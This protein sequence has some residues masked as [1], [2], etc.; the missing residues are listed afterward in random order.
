MFLYFGTPKTSDAMFLDLRKSSTPKYLTADQ[1]FCSLHIRE[2]FFK[3]HYSKRN[4]REN[5]SLATGGPA[6]SFCLATVD[7]MVSI[8]ASDLVLVLISS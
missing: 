1:T 2:L 4:T 3:H 6:D 8:V 7:E 5:G